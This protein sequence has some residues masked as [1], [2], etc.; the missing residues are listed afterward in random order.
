M[1]VARSVGAL[2]CVLLFVSTALAQSSQPGMTG[3]SAW[4]N[5]RG[6]TLYIESV[7]P[8]GQ[9]TGFY[10]N[11]AQGFNCQNTP[12]PVT[13]WVLGT[14]ITFAVLWQNSAESCNSLTAWTGFYNTSTNAIVTLWQLVVNGTTSKDQ[15]LQGQDTFTQFAQ[16]RLKS[17]K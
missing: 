5:E 6:S 14:A 3:P 15:I 11:R 8:S 12:Y 7:S 2:A 10:V 1:Y 9:L 4:M 13:G 17:M 16:K